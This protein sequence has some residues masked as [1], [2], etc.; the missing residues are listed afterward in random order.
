MTVQWEVDTMR[1]ATC[2]AMLIIAVA[3]GTSTGQLQS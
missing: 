2:D 1:N 3:R